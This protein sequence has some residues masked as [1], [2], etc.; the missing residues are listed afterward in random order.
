MSLMSKNK[1]SLKWSGQKLEFL[2]V[3]LPPGQ[4]EWFYGAEKLFLLDKDEKTNCID[5]CKQ[6]KIGL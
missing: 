4:Y 3:E 1:K 2:R 6:K 5:V